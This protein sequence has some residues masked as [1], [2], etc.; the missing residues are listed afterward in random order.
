MQAAIGALRGRYGLG[1]PAWLAGVGCLVG[2]PGLQRLADARQRA[3]P[4]LAGGPFQLGDGADAEALL[5][6]PCPDRSDAR[7]LQQVRRFGR[8][9]AFQLLQV[10]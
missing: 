10:A 6:Q 9:F 8:N 7:D 3:Q 5:N 1:A 2:D 4:M